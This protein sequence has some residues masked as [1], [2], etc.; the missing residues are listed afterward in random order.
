M[1][2]EPWGGKLGKKVGKFTATENTCYRAGSETGRVHLG[3][4]R[5]R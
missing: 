3:E 1:K 2:R 5:K 4:C